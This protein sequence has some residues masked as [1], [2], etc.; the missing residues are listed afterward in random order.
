MT[1]RYILSGGE[2]NAENV[3]RLLDANANRAREG[4]RTA[5]DFI[6]FSIGDHRWAMRL[7]SL[8]H[9]VTE[10]LQAYVPD[11]VLAAA[12]NVIEDAGHPDRA[13]A[14]GAVS[15]GELPREVARRG[16]KRAQEALRVLEEYIRGRAPEAAGAYARM[17][18]EAYAAEQWLAEGSEVSRILWQAKLYVLLTEALCVRNVEETARAALQGGAR[19]LQLREKDATDSALLERAR[20]LRDL[21]AEHQA[22]LV[23]NDRPAVAW[24]ARAAGVHLGQADL[25]PQAVR[26]WAGSQLLIGR[27]THSPEQALRAARE[28][29]VDYIAVGA[30]YETASKKGY[31]LQGPALA[32]EAARM[33]LGVPVFAIGGITVERV[34]E[35]K[36]AGVGRVAVSSAVVSAADP[37]GAARQLVE[38]LAA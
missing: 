23:V 15:P 4:F 9:G 6:R 18:F 38:A 11:E 32:R 35:L 10:T 34:A 19:I 12:R 37:Q 5:E 16:L 28:E 7:R 13:E 33:D 26:G 1:S 21:C 30:M 25:P 31:T 17:R 20:R 14:L 29:G 27:S 2:V 24:A 3:L 36:A 8:R 22:L